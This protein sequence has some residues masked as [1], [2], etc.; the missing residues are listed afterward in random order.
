MVKQRLI[1]A[2]NGAKIQL[3]SPEVQCITAGSQRRLRAPAAHLHHRLLQPSPECLAC[4]PSP[5][6]RSPSIGC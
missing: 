2:Q 3:K 1:Q 5:P 6:L 4:H